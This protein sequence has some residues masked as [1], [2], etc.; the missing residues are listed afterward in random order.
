M[1]TIIKQHKIMMYMS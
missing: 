1:L